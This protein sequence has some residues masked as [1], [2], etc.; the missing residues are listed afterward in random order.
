MKRMIL[1]P[2]MMCADMMNVER[3]LRALEEEGYY[4]GEYASPVSS[5]L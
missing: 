2:S 1:A 5:I 4:L 3:D